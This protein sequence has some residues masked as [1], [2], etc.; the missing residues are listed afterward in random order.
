MMNIVPIIKIVEAG[1][2]LYIFIKLYIF[3][4][5][6]KCILVFFVLIILFN[7][8]EGRRAYLRKWVLRKR[9]R[10]RLVLFSKIL[11]MFPLNSFLRSTFP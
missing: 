9:K 5:A 6:I 7:C 8:K 1:F 2:Q 4:D 3:N 10:T 11:A